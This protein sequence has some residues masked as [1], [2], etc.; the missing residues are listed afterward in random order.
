DGPRPDAGH[1]GAGRDD[2]AAGRGGR[3]HV[4]RDPAAHA[5]DPRSRVPPG[6]R[7]LV[8]MTDAPRRLRVGGLSTANIATENVIPGVR[9][10]TRCEVAAIASRDAASA[11]AVARRLDIPR[12]HGS[13][14]ALLADPDI[15]A[16][17]IPLPNH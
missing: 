15:D 10:G 16:G 3:G 8:G 2:G 4:R 7:G 5:P 13:Y 14:E 11:A 1:A 12:A 9:R 6:H 17:Y